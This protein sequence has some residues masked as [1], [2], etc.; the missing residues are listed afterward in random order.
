MRFTKGQRELI[1]EK[2]VMHTILYH[3]KGFSSGVWSFWGNNRKQQ[4][5][6]YVLCRS[7]AINFRT[8]IGGLPIYPIIIYTKI[9]PNALITLLA[10]SVG[11][12]MNLLVIVYSATGSRPMIIVMLTEHF[13]TR[14]RHN[15]RGR[16]GGTCPT[17]LL[18]MQG[19]SPVIFV[20]VLSFGTLVV[21][22]C[23]STSKQR[24]GIE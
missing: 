1:P 10:V 3:W 6:Q 23:S 8:F 19:T 11:I 4:R 20:S 7:T 2:K 18:D 13:G 24:V 15:N 22:F 21:M 16:I 14:H 5:I 17:Q 9:V 12:F